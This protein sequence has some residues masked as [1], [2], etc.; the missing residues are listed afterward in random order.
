MKDLLRDSAKATNRPAVSYICP[1]LAA[2]KYCCYLKTSPLHVFHS[3]SLNKYFLADYTKVWSHKI[4][5]I[6]HKTD[7]YD[8]IKNYLSSLL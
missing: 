1:I 3:E 8:L 6:N 4:N 2:W 5:Y 7:V